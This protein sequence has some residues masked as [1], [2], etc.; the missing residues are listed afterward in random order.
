MKAH[1]SIIRLVWI[2]RPDAP[3]RCA[4][5]RT[6][7][8]SQIRPKRTRMIECLFSVHKIL[9]TKHEISRL[10]S[11]ARPE[12]EASLYSH[13]N[14]RVHPRSV[15]AQLPARS[16]QAHPSHERPQRCGAIA[17]CPSVAPGVPSREPFCS[18][19][20]D[21]ANGHV[22]GGRIRTHLCERAAGAIIW[23]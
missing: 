16:D 13:G 22:Q 9:K 4:R 19:L 18:S 21:V 20:Q 6:Q 17:T 3:P 23:P 12:C 10:S 14:Q 7:K 5:N 8:L 1:C 11:L 2:L 15:Q